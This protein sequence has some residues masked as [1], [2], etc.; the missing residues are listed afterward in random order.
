MVEG[1]LDS[2]AGFGFEAGFD[3]VRDVDFVAVDWQQGCWLPL[4]GCLG[5][6]SL[7]RFYSTICLKS[8]DFL[9]LVQ[10]CKKLAV[11]YCKI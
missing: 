5:D 11:K 9:V 6:S 3:I 7:K 2:F 4:W 1:V 8:F 10:I